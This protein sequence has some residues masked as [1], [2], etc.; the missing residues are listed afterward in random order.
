MAETTTGRKSQ[1]IDTAA[2]LFREKG[3][4]A[5]SMRDLAQVLGIE[6][7]SIYSHIKS[8]EE[9]LETICFNMARQFLT[10]INEVND[11]Y[12]SAEEK[13]RTAIKS[14]VQI[15]TSHPDH[16]SVFIKEWRGLSEPKL[17]EFKSLRDTYENQFR[18]ILE[19][20]ENED[21]FERVDNKFAVLTIL[22][23]VNWINE[24]YSPE[25]NM[26]PEEIAKKLS[27]FMLGGLRKKFVT[28]LNYKP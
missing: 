7:S 24:W 27:D 21:I 2:R 13:L 23:A 3:Y 4:E 26:A 25:G 8:K 10:A 18:I 5:S 9:L 1:I 14:H 12:F 28:D 6:A 15:I 20:G 17:S 16:S 11:I 19:E 22:S